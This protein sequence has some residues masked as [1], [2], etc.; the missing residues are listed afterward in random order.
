M[1]DKADKVPENVPGPYYVDEECIACGI[2]IETAPENF[3]M[4]EDGS[5][6]YVYRQ[7]E[8]DEEIDTCEDALAECPVD[9]IGNDG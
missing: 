5:K 3:K 8:T 1:A 6:A 4:N 7:P 2:C 9:A